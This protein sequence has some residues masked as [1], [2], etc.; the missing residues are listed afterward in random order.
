MTV[1]ATPLRQTYFFWS[2]TAAFIFRQSSKPVC[3]FSMMEQVRLCAVWPTES[4]IGSSMNHIQ[5]W[6][7]VWICYCHALE[8]G[9]LT[10]GRQQPPPTTTTMTAMPP[11]RTTWTRPRRRRRQLR[12]AMLVDP[13]AAGWVESIWWLKSLFL[14]HVIINESVKVTPDLKNSN[15]SLERLQ[16]HAIMIVIRSVSYRQWHNI[17]KLFWFTIEEYLSYLLPK[18]GDL[19]PTSLGSGAI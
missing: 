11:P 18:F 5:G 4:W 9:C 15:Y 3:G 17:T 13:R 19:V 16:W 10:S 6:M 12:F 7:P 2:M 8:K 14:T 1:I